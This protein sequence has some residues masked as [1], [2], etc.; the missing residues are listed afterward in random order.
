MLALSNGYEMRLV[1]TSRETDAGFDVLHA[2]GAGLVSTITRRIG[3]QG[4]AVEDTR[5]FATV[6]TPSD[7]YRIEHAAGETIAYSQRQ[8]DNRQIAADYRLPQ[9]DISP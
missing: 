7:T 4:D 9:M 2:R 3:D 8:L 6:A 1:L 5:F